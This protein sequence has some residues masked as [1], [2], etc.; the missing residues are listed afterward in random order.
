MIVHYSS[1]RGLALQEVEDFCRFKIVLG[2]LP[3]RRPQVPELT[4]VDND[5]ALIGIDIV[6]TLPGAP[7]DPAWRAEYDRMISTAA[8][9]GW[10]DETSNFI[11][12]HVERTSPL[13][14]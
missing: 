4:F 6:P 12:A 1:D 10:I 8:R 9:F 3:D 2:C 7:T 13:V 5:N 14:I 11:R